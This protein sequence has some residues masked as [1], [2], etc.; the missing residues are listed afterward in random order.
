M[1]HCMEAVRATSGYSRP[2]QQH[3]VDLPLF[4]DNKRLN[5]IS[6]I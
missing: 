5:Q 4:I 3:I 6:V 2:K 1:D